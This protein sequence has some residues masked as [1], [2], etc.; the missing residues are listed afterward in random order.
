MG[1]LRRTQILL[2]REQHERLVE[3]AR[4]SKRS[5]SDVVRETLRER[6]A[7]EDRR[8]QDEEF[9]EAMA[10]LDRF[11]EEMAAKHGILKVDLVEE[12]RQ[13][14]D[15]WLDPILRDVR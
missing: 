10:R 4:R 9:R 2:E 14:A 6:L 7:E 13:E 11:C 12:V 5:V 1:A 8:A 15:G 3:M